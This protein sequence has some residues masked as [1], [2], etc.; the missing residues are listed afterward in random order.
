MQ[1]PPSA[2]T[3]AECSTSFRVS[4]CIPW[5]I[6]RS[7]LGSIAWD[8]SMTAARCRSRTRRSKLRWPNGGGENTTKFTMLP[9]FDLA[10]LWWVRSIENK[11]NSY[12]WTHKL[13]KNI[14]EMVATETN[15][16]RPVAGITFPHKRCRWRV[17]EDARSRRSRW[18]DVV[19]VM[20][21]L[22]ITRSCTRLHNRRRPRTRSHVWLVVVSST[23]SVQR[24]S[25]IR[26]PLDTPT[27]TSPSVWNYELKIW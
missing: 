1:S 9:C 15:P 8:R 10:Q 2:P 25:G 21:H 4:I 7:T 24:G 13:A 3:I 26:D 17:E 12:A 19:N 6:C 14:Y 23:P 22:T 18:L 11:K 27:L 16:Q 20:V 5:G